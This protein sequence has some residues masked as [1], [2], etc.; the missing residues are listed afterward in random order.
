MHTGSGA[1][2]VNAGLGTQRNYNQ[3]S[4]SN[5]KQ[6]NAETQNFRG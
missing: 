3:S 5:N 6:Y 1:M 4:G 2:L